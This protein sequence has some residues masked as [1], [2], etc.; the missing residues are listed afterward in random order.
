MI[1][2]DKNKFFFSRH[3]IKTPGFILEE[4]SRDNLPKEIPSSEPGTC[5]FLNGYRHPGVDESNP[6]DAHIQA[7]VTEYD[8]TCGM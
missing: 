2:D 3:L 4:R 8:I 6:L 7:A 1:I 5:H